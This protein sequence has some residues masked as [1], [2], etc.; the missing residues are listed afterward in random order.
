MN[1]VSISLINDVKK[2]PEGGFGL[3]YH[4]KNI[5]NVNQNKTNRLKRNVMASNHWRATTNANNSA[6]KY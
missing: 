1:L 4:Q 2:T 5:F 3:I 6:K